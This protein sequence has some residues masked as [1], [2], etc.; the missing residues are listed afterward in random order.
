MSLARARGPGHPDKVCDAVAANIVEEYLKRDPAAQM[1]IRVCGGQGVMFVAGEVK[2]TADFDVSAVVRRTVAACG[3]SESVEPFITIEPMAPAWAPEIGSRD[4][5]TVM[6]YATSQTPERLPPIVVLAQKIAAELERSRIS[7]PDWFW[8]GSDYEVTVEDASKPWS[9]NL[10]AEH[11]DGQDVDSVRR[12]LESLVRQQAPDATLK[13]NPA[14]EETCAGLS[15]RIG[16]SGRTSSADQYGTTL[17][18]NESGVGRHLNH[19]L[20]AGAELARQTAIKLVNQ[21]R[22]Q[23]ILVNMVWQPL[24][25]RPGGVRARNEKGEDLTRLIDGAF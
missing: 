1:N 21:G 9:I 6:G 22:G 19:P 8:L 5:V 7:D 10:R 11:A 20:N 25:A 14:G 16:S 4:V 12:Q 13:I 18:A 23:A 17:P 3:V 2:S 24:E 15:V